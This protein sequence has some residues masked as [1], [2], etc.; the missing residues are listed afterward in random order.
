MTTARRQRRRWRYNPWVSAALAWLAAAY[1]LL[2][3]RTGRWH[4]DC[5]PA[6][7]LLIK[8]G[9]P[10]ICAFWHGRLI[11]SFAAW[12]LLLRKLGVA[13]N[14][15][16]HVMISTH[17]DGELIHRAA[18]RLGAKTVRGS[19]R[20][21]GFKVL[22]A[23]RRVLREG[24]ILALT[25]DGPRGPRMR[26]QAGVAFLAAKASVP[27]VPMT[28][29]TRHQRTLRSWDRFMLVWPFARGRIAFGDPV[30]APQDGDIEAYRAL[31]EERMIRFS[32]EIDGSQGI[33]P[34]QPAA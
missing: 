15:D 8:S 31:I 27:V 24:G 29:A 6:T 28:F 22:V 14:A 34:I 25:P 4:V 10:F 17:G 1:I 7:E 18:R 16:L 19:S 20:R 5:T 9:T 23:A 2:I 26:S 32:H 13:H 30:T 21:G 3:G 33:D 12:S 11:M